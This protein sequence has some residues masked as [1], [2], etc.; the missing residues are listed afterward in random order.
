MEK[1]KVNLNIRQSIRTDLAIEAREN[2]DSKEVDGVKTIQKDYKSCTITHVEILN[3]NGSETLG[4][5][6]GNYITIESTKMRENDIESH[7]DIIKK[8]SEYIKKLIDMNDVKPKNTLVVGLGNR[9]VTPD[10][11]GP[12]TVS[13]VLVTRHI[14]DTVSDDINGSV[15]P[16]CAVSPGVMGVT[17]IETGDIIKGITERIKPDLIIAID[18]LAARRFSRINATIQMSDIGIIPGAGVG[19]KR[20]ALNKET[21]GVPVIAIGVPTVV[22]AG[23][24]VNDTMDR[25]LGQMIEYAEEGTDIYKTLQSLDHEEKYKLITDILTP[26]AENMFVTPKEVDAVIDRLS[27]IIGNAI[28]ISLHDGI[29]TEDINR[30][31][32]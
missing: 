9:Y 13:K 30:Y 4:K 2:I 31:K 5:P 25:I 28:N 22:D 10:A 20:M 3:E 26:Y 23:T 18:A 16:V 21:L 12:K 19:N 24:L 17:G 6:I 14:M 8:C 27:N 7:E 1:D 29:T 32:Y 11:L 15:S